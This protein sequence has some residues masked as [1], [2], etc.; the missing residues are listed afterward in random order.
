MDQDSAGD[1]APPLLRHR[2]AQRDIVR[3]DGD[4][5]RDAAGPRDFCCQ[6]EIEPVARI[7]LDDEECARR[8]GGGADGSQYRIDGGRG[9]D[10]ARDRGV[11]H[12]GPDI[13]GM[14]R[15]MAGAAAGD[16]R[17]LA[18]GGRGEVAAQHDVVLRQQ[19]EPGMQR[20]E[21][22]KH[23]PDDHSGVVDQ[24]L[25]DVLPAA[26]PA[27]VAGAIPDVIAILPRPSRRGKP[28]RREPVALTGPLDR[29][30]ADGR[31][32]ARNCEYAAAPR[33]RFR[34]AQIR[35]GLEKFE[36]SV[37]RDEPFSVR[38]ISRAAQLRAGS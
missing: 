35:Y 30:A 10:V 1:A 6:A 17:D 32:A 14:G 16:H 15:L 31:V 28:S 23:L 24:L 25:H 33:R 36:A 34:E 8:P 5:G 37:D 4:L 9:E 12:A 2:V 21:S 26:C 18:A 11:Q 20:D 38:A 7:V 22:F 27:A 29:F 13:A 19:G 3:D